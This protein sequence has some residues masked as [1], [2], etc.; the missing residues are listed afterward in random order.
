MKTLLSLARYAVTD[1]CQYP[2]LKMKPYLATKVE[3]DLKKEGRLKGRP[4]FLD[5]DFM[6]RSMNDFYAF[7]NEHF[8]PWFFAVEGLNNSLKWA[9]NYLSVYSY[10]HGTLSETESLSKLLRTR[11]SEAN[12]FVIDT[13]L[14]LSALF[15]S[16]KYSMQDD[17]VLAEYKEGISEKHNALLEDVT[18]I[19]TR[20]EIIFR[21][22][23]VMD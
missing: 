1:I 10:F 20:M 7:V 9:R 21:T 19:I 2:F 16:G 18:D 13:M 5:Y 11:A 4:G 12:R 15:E 6:E 14:Q 22:R 8:N 17:A 3:K 23:K